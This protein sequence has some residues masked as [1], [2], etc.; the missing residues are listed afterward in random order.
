[1]LAATL[2]I[3]PPS[4]ATSNVAR[5]FCAGSITVPPFSS[6]SYMREPP[7]VS[8]RLP[9]EYTLRLDPFKPRL[10]YVQPIPTAGDGSHDAEHAPD[11]HHACRQLA[12]AGRCS[13]AGHS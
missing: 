10:L 3:L 1:M 7:P 11:S 5:M 2:A 6:R 13:C 9:G 4:T 12:A 8:A